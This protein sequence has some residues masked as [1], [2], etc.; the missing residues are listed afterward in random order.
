MIPN[1]RNLFVRACFPRPLQ[2]EIQFVAAN[3]DGTFAATEED[4]T[5][6]Q[7]TGRS[8]QRL[9]EELASRVGYDVMACVCAGNHGA[10]TPLLTDLPRSRETLRIVLLRNNTPGHD[11]TIFPDM[12]ALSDF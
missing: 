10:I 7:F 11:Q 8:V 2:R 1:R 12:D 5:S 4:W 3:D 6:F 9:R